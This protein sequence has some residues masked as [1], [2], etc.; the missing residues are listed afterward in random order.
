[1][2]VVASGCGLA[3]AAPAF[4]LLP[5]PVALVSLPFLIPYAAI[6]SY[7]DGVPLQV[8]AFTRVG[9]CTKG[10]PC[11]HCG[12]GGQGAYCATVMHG[13]S[14]ARGSMRIRV[15]GLCEV[16]AHG[17]GRTNGLPVVGERRFLE[18]S[19]AA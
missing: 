12:K 14:H 6:L 11:R 8:L 19:C 17:C 7:G 9:P 3:Q 1:M 10:H 16:A 4:R 15:P 18:L 2:A 13:G 5:L